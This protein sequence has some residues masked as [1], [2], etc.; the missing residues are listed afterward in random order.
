MQ[1]SSR[2]DEVDYHQY[3]CLC[4]RLHSALTNHLQLKEHN[5]RVLPCKTIRALSSCSIFNLGYGCL[6]SFGC[7]FI[8]SRGY[9][10]MFKECVEYQQAHR[11]HL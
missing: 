1:T 2:S 6:D 8:H 3:N 11:G 5:G 7:T 4:I 10:S 9:N